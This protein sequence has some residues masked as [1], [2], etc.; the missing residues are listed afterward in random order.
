M[1]VYNNINVDF[2]EFFGRCEHPKLVYTRNGSYVLQSCGRCAACVYRRNQ[3]YS[4]MT[5]VQASKYKYTVFV[6]LDYYNCYLPQF[7][8]VLEEKGDNYVLKGVN[9]SSRC[10]VPPLLFTSCM[11]KQEFDLYRDKANRP[12]TRLHGTFGYCYTPDLQNF[13][14][15]LRYYLTKQNCNDIT[16]FAISEYGPQTFRPH[17][18]L[19]LFTDRDDTHSHLYECCHKAWKFGSV[20]WATANVRVSSYLTDY[21]NSTALIPDFLRTKYVRPVT[22]HSNYYASLLPCIDKAS[23]YEDPYRYITEKK[24]SISGKEIPFPFWRN[25]L[26]KLLWRPPGYSDTPLHQLPGIY[27]AYNRIIKNLSIDVDSD[28]AKPINLAR[29]IFNHRSNPDCRRVLDYFSNH[30][31]YSPHL[32]ESDFCVAL[33]GYLRRS[34]DFYNYVCDSNDALVYKRVKAIYEYY[35]LA[36]YE[37]LRHFYVLIGEYQSKISADVSAFYYHNHFFSASMPNYEGNRLN[38]FSSSLEE[39]QFYREA[40]SYYARKCSEAIKHK[41]L[42]DSNYIF[43]KDLPIVKLK[44]KKRKKYGKHI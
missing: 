34:R 36:S 13:L 4:L 9:I 14:K 19:L 44:P 26:T 27:N 21:C 12:S 2:R 40:R 30:T 43:C 1:K 28:L 32:E 16:Y 29:Y 42:N 31:S 11:S 10:K 39:N 22:L 17:F 35:Q 6:T 38:Q 41:D 33:A 8:F 23:F 24:Y 5:Q 3:R 37:Q 25:L 18:H 7:R 20:D 15:R